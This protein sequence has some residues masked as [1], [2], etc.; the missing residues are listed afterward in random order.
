MPLINE[1]SI[2]KYPIFAYK[3]KGQLYGTAAFAALVAIMAQG[4]VGA[5]MEKEQSSK[6]EWFEANSEM[7]DIH[8]Q[9]VA[10]AKR[11]LD[12][13]KVNFLMQAVSREYI[14]SYIH[15]GR[16]MSG[17]RHDL[18]RVQLWEHDPREW[19]VLDLAILRD[20]YVHWLDERLANNIFKQAIASSTVAYQEL[21]DLSRENLNFKEQIEWYCKKHPEKC[22]EHR[23]NKEKIARKQGAEIARLK[24]ESGILNLGLDPVDF[25]ISTE[26][27]TDLEDKM[28]LDVTEKLA[29]DP[30]KRHL[31]VNEIDLF[32]KSEVFQ[33]L[34][35]DLWTKHNLSQFYKGSKKIFQ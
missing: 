18:G 14:Y 22:N 10:N 5:P 15:T 20:I 25:D 23:E 19:F 34:A 35:Q 8:Q 30:A 16:H 2:P 32:K 1:R 12:N 26:L 33:E 17:R 27:R 29:E 28:I 4:S 31:F 3:M 7:I 24:N 11:Y 13:L 6:P 9:D 21:K